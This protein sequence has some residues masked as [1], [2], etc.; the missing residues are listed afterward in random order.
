MRSRRSTVAL[1]ATAFDPE[2]DRSGRSPPVL[3]V[4]LVGHPVLKW[5]HAPSARTR[6]ESR[7]R[8]GHAKA[9]SPFP[10]RQRGRLSNPQAGHRCAT[11]ACLRLARLAQQRDCG[12]R[13]RH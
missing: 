10:R 8:C 12:L 11:V 3:E 4:S 13:Q 2:A 9:M 6:T 7:S 5:I 1:L